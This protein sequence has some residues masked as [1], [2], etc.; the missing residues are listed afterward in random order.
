MTTELNFNNLLE[1]SGSV[2]EQILTEREV[3]QARKT[4]SPELKKYLSKHL[5][6]LLRIAFRENCDVATLM[7]LKELSARTRKY[8][9]CISLLII[10]ERNHTEKTGIVMLLILL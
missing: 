5:P 1:M 4:N 6:R 8:P 3:E 2:I 9:S 10:P 7:A